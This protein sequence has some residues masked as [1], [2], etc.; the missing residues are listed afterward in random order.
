MIHL[1]LL[2]RDV[3]RKLAKGA[4][5]PLIRSIEWRLVGKAQAR[6]RDDRHRAF[7]QRPAQG[8]DCQGGGIILVWTISA[9]RVAFEKETFN[10]FY[11]IKM[12]HCTAMRSLLISIHSMPHSPRLLL[13]QSRTAGLS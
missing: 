5:S 11:V 8:S 7:H 10:E 6:R 3:A 1:K 13:H 9:K 2:R 12:G 4:V